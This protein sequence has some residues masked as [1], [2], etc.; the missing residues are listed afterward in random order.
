[1]FYRIFTLVFLTSISFLAQAQSLWQDVGE[2][3][4][5]VSEA[6]RQIKPNQYRMLSLDF[7][8]VKKKLAAAPKWVPGVVPENSM[9]LEL[10][11]PDKG[12]QRFK[13]V[14]ASIFAKALADKY[15]EIKS[16]KGWG[17][18]DPT[19]TLRFDI[20]PQGFRA[21][22]I[23]E[24]GSWF[25]DPYS[26]EDTKYYMAYHKKDLDNDEPFLC[27]VEGGKLAQKVLDAPE[28]GDCQFRTYRLALA[29]TGEYAQFHG[30]TVAGV[31]AA[32]NTSM[33]RVNGVY[34]RE[35]A[36]T[37]VIVGNNDQLVFLD[38]NTDP[39]TN[40]D[41][42]AML[43]QNQATVDNIIGTA[44]YDIGHV[45]S[46]GGGGIASLFAPCSSYKAQGVTGRGAP[47]GDA[48]D[49]DYVAHEMGHQFGANH[50]QN[51]GC[52]RNNPTAMEP[53][54]ASTIMG[55]AG[56]CFPN[57]QSNSDDYFHTIS[58]QE[59]QG[60]IT[61]GTGS[62]CP[63]TVAINN[64]K[65]TVAG[66]AD[67]TI[68]V[69]TPFVL[70]AV[71]A[72]ADSDPI[73]YCWEQMDPETGNMP[74]ESTSTLGPLFRSIAPT[75][76]SKR[77]FP[78]LSAI[79]AN[80]T[81]QWEVLPSVSRAMKFRVSIRDNH[82]GGGCVETD[83][84]VITSSDVAGPFVV[85]QP[86]TALDWPAQSIQTVTWDVANTN[87]APVN[88]TMVDI[89][90]SLDG[91]NT[92]P[93]TLATNTPNDGSHSVMMPVQTS[94]TAR[95]MVKG[96]NNVFFDIS[97]TNF[98]ISAA[99]S[100]FA[101]TLSQDSI[102]L[103]APVTQDMS[104]AVAPIAGFTGDVSIATSNVPAGLDVIPNPQS[105]T[106]PGTS[107]VNITASS[108]LSGSYDVYFDVTGST[109]T[110]SKVLNVFVANAA[111]TGISLMLPSNGATGVS[112]QP[113]LKWS[114]VANAESYFVEVFSDDGLTNLV[115]SGSVT[116][117]SF[118]VS[119]DL[120]PDSQYYWRVTATNLCGNEMSSVFS[121]S[122]L[123]IICNV[124]S[125]TDLPIAISS[126]S[127]STITST[128]HI[129]ESGE[130]ASIKVK[131]LDIT[132]SWIQDLSVTLTAPDG[133]EVP[134]F[135][136]LCGDYSN[137]LINFDDAA[138][139]AYSSIP[140]PPIG[141]ETY[142]PLGQL[143]SLL[144][145]QVNGDWVVT[146]QDSYTDDGG[147]LNAWSLDLCFLVDSLT[148]MVNPTDVA[149]FGGS[150]GSA[151]VIVAG[152]TPPYTYTWSA[153]NGTDLSAGNYAVTVTDA[154]SNTAS[155]SFVI[156]QPTDL[157]LTGSITDASPGGSDGA[158]DLSVTGGI[159]NY[160]YNWSNNQTTQD[161]NNLAANSYQVTVVD[162]NSCSKTKSFV[163]GESCGIP[164]QFSVAIQSSS[165]ADISWATVAGADSYQIRYRVV[166]ATT[167]LSQTV[168][169][170][171]VS[172]SG[173]TP[174]ANY[175]YQV[176]SHCSS[177]WSAYSSTNN[178]TLPAPCDMPIN[179]ATV[180]VL[181]NAATLT[182]NT[183]SGASGYVA[184]YRPLGAADWLEQSTTSNSI[185]LSGL[186]GSTSYEFIVKTECGNFS[187][188][189]NS[190]FVFTTMMACSPPADI[191]VTNL[192]YTSFQLD[193]GVI[194]GVSQFSVRYRVVGTTNWS[195][196]NVNT[197]TVVL[198][199]LDAG[200]TYEYQIQSKCGVAWSDF[201]ELAQNTL[202]SGCEVNGLTSG[203]ITSSS[204][205]LN[206][207]ATT[208]ATKYQIFY[209]LAG[210]GNT[211]LNQ[212][213]TTTSTIIEGLDENSV[214]S[215]EVRAFC[216]YGWGAKTSILNVQTSP[217]GI[218]DIDLDQSFLLY[219]N[220]VASSL[221]L[222]FKKK[223]LSIGVFD[224]LGQ[225][226]LSEKADL[227]MNISVEI[228]K[229][230]CYFI[231]AIYSDGRRLG[232]K[233]VKTAR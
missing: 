166:G 148:V 109:G 119:S 196:V 17:I 156:N 212:E 170:N 59:I 191:V 63:T 94:T 50:T 92:Y 228:L 39:Y 107:N 78:A 110:V 208:S 105:L 216:A 43:N 221:V 172:L 171:M 184:N 99:Q 138:N 164:S 61:S 134:L 175:E 160:S 179:V 209:V 46:T 3:S 57:V 13:V 64:Q 33:T 8:G 117:D 89:F 75:V 72:D 53:G 133:T 165:A 192:T 103:C 69:S 82:Q 47:V 190:S 16:Y 139:S 169:T 147:S 188:N 218:F 15:P 31:L 142:Q 23:T 127:I 6:D 201:S 198:D 132:H 220:P 229:P 10:P 155:V 58:I 153:G 186:M 81:P 85:T 52:N 45:F 116:V 223:P 5:V 97:N 214:Y 217:D 84:V 87:V 130:L 144:G 108:S 14:E 174:S 104:L 126:T 106:V 200:A 79:I 44:N 68:P 141:N 226:V 136:E 120:N 7:Q 35:L 76:D 129:G 140:C 20:S 2:Q 67:F 199:N 115:T 123:A 56:I 122:T 173:L 24:S 202:P 149:C 26:T 180:T 157:V 135:G 206:W 111:P 222:E 11:T 185:T 88:A 183:V 18:D 60:N 32:M 62:G 118:K 128:I 29:C 30:G 193:W 137:I 231:Q 213:V 27:G 194:T 225:E 195:S 151:N 28:Y 21:M 146:V 9:V 1:M 168:T 34:E 224:V 22:V 48:F 54:S 167:W 42:S 161:I 182:W 158:I 40:N 19:A 207:D 49:I 25:L 210:S 211:P 80:T 197:E 70:D 41:G 98:T 101:V 71:G 121:F 150:T 113:T 215:I 177:G 55:Y 96:H 203:A 162:A 227:K 95:I 233:F 86:N 102:S 38:A 73:T 189:F 205:E 66:G 125:A 219:P 124:Y 77:Y 93:V 36:V 83:D 181:S 230:G 12:V 163:V 187:S 65:P 232:R 112:L 178:F 145:K 37:M 204:I 131:N 114:Q 100:G 154:I 90:L 159:A 152:G 143:N 4:I 176:Q 74:P 91:G 51:N